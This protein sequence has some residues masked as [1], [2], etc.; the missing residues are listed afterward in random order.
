ML[1]RNRRASVKTKTGAGGFGGMKI[2][3]VVGSTGEYS[4]QR[5]W[6]VKAF[7]SKL[8]AEKLKLLCELEVDR[9]NTVVSV[10]EEYGYYDQ[11][12]HGPSQFD[13]FFDMSY[14]STYYNIEEVELEN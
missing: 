10:D 4:D 3:I 13:P 7:Y 9:I 1:F 5:Q 6:N 11:E 2:Y 14:T 8:K 12:R